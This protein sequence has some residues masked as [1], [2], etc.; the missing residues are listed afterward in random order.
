MEELPHWFDTGHFTV[1][2]LIPM[3]KLSSRSTETSYNS[4]TINYHQ[5]R[6]TKTVWRVVHDILNQLDLE[7]IATTY[8]KLP[9]KQEQQEII[10][11]RYGNVSGDYYIDGLI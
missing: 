8:I 4:D 2:Q 7:S 3:R 11:R 1:T 6:S 10:I 5:K 9:P